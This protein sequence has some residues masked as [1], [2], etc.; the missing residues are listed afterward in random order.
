MKNLK[1]I[2]YG[3][4][5][6]CIAGVIIAILSG[7]LPMLFSA[8]AFAVFFV[9]TLFAV[10]FLVLPYVV[11]GIG[12]GLGKIWWLLRKIGQARDTVARWLWGRR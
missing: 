4:L 12:W 7:G 1:D 2:F 5:G 10:F 3:W 9:I 11:E 6:I 8:N